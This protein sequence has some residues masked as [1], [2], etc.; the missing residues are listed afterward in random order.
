MR[1]LVR[2]LACKTCLAENII[3][4][5]KAPTG[6]T[7]SAID[8]ISSPPKIGGVARQAIL[9]IA[10]DLAGGGTKFPGGWMINSLQNL[11]I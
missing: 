10:P 9:L 1:G 6:T 2:A 11:T 8:Q 7:D 4:P 3:D 5:M